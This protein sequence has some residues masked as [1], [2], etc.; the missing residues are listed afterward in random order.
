MAEALEVQW[1]RTLGP[2]MRVAVLCGGPG[3]K[4]EATMDYARTAVAQLDTLA[5]F[6]DGAALPLFHRAMPT[7]AAHALQYAALMPRRTTALELVSDAPPTCLAHGILQASLD[8]L[9]E[10]VRYLSVLPFYF[11]LVL[12]SPPQNRWL[13]GHRQR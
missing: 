7:E 8:L 13:D 12:A 1:G 9:R 11:L 3:L 2:Y 6:G 10:A 5:R 4:R